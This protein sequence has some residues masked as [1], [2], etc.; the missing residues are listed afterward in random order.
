MMQTPSFLLRGAPMDG[1]QAECGRC[2]DF[3]LQSVS[4]KITQLEPVA[5]GRQETA[6]RPAPWLGLFAQAPLRVDGD[7]PCPARKQCHG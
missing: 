5:S 3:V 6:A 2:Q 7:D 1:T 4:M